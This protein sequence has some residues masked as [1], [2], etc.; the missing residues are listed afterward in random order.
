MAI[1]RIKASNFKSFKNLDIE[2]G[3]FN[4]LIGA[5]AAGKSNFISIFRFLKDAATVGLDYAVS[6]QGGVEFFRNMKIGDLPP[7][8]RTR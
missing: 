3:K 1:K 7:I 8:K 4:L 6:M 5:N 2:L